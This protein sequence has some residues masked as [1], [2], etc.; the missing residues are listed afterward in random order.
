MIRDSNIDWLRKSKVLR[1][2]RFALSTDGTSALVA[3]D[4]GA[5]TMVEISTF[6]ASGLA[7]GATGDKAT[8]IDFDIVREADLTQDIGF[9]VLWLANSAPE[10]TDA[11]LFAIHTDQFDVGEPLVT[12][13]TVLDTV[14]AVQSPSTTTALQL[15]RTSRGIRTGGTWDPTA[16]KGG[17]LIELNVGT[18]TTFDANQV[19]VLGV[20]VDYIPKL[21]MS[22]GEDQGALNADLGAA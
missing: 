22:V 11:I 7:V 4:T 13:A 20:E 14:I 18:F 12:A 15:H 8:L 9:R 16:R 1:P 3:P 10:L 17:L 19:L 21:C 6:G 2:E 5:M